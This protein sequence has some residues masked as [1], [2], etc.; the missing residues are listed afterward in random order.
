VLMPLA[1]PED[2]LAVIDPDL[3]EDHRAPPPS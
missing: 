3:D 2:G 1:E